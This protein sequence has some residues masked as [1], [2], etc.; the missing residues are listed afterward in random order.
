MPE[1]TPLPPL[2]EDLVVRMGLDALD[3]AES[4]ELER[5][6]AAVEDATALV[7]AEVT[8]ATAARW[9]A[10]L[11]AVV[12]VVIRSAAR[13]AFENPRGIQQET[14]GEH[15]V[16]LTDT[17]GVFLTARE[18]AL[19]AKAASG[20][21]GGYV[22]SVRTPSGYGIPPAD[23]SIY[24]PVTGSRPLPFTRLKDVL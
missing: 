20:R 7:F 19:I 22:G 13:R 15:T 1:S 8:E 9:E 24:L 2:V 3:L 21:K 4:G 18:S 12:A 16:G 17:S 11:P 5:L 10:S 6:T 23:A 14:L